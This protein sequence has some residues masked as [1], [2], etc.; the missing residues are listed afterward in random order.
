VKEE[1]RNVAWAPYQVSSLGRVRRMTR[2]MGTWPGR[3]LRLRSNADGSGYLSVV[4][5][6]EGKQVFASVSSLVAEAFIGKRPAGKEV[7]HKD[8]NKWNNQAS[9]LQYKTPAQNVQ[10]S[11]DAGHMGRL[12]S[13][14]GMAR[15]TEQQVDRIR[16]EY[17]PRIVTYS[18]LAKRYGVA[19]STVAA[20]CCRNTWKHI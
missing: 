3:I 8:F 6:F 16:G 13:K 10:R 2:G 15:L 4:L 12:G 14:H 7:D 17:R 19:L 1:G 9:N 18:A 20:V 11:A 5:C